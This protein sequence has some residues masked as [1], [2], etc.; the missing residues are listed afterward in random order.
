MPVFQPT[1]QAPPGWGGRDRIPPIRYAGAPAVDALPPSAQSDL[2][3]YDPKGAYVYAATDYRARGPREVE[4]CAA[5]SHHDYLYIGTVVLS[6]AASIYSDLHYFQ[7]S[8]YPGVRLIGPGLLGVTWGAT[9]GGTY[10]ALPKCSP[11]W[12]ASAPPEGDFRLNWPLA[13][14]LG[15]L[16]GAT[17]PVLTGYETGGIPLEWAV[18]ERSARVF[19][20]A[21]GGLVG[22]LIP[23]VLPPKT[24]RAAKELQ[25][26]RASGDSAGAFVSYTVR[27]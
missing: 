4:L 26:I 3:A 15:M 18:W 12:V 2:G 23:Y 16:A 1:T 7:F 20:S 9:L 17:A 5:A 6:F 19:V 13:I 22:A 8:P 25:H 24:W 21:G 11:D 27:F 14:A 10:L